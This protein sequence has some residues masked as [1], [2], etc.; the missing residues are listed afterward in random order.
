MPHSSLLWKSRPKVGCQ[1]IYDSVSPTLFDDLDS[2]KLCRLFYGGYV[3]DKL[4]QYRFLRPCLGGKDFVVA[5]VLAV[6]GDKAK[7]PCTP[8]YTTDITNLPLH[9]DDF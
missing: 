3:G 6:H 7:S 2:S 9:R 1:V 8:G 5:T 4:Y